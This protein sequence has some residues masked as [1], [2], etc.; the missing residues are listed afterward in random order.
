MDENN[1]LSIKKKRNFE[2]LLNVFFT[3]E[4][5]LIMIIFILR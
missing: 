2:N 4:L 1:L 5:A 3:N